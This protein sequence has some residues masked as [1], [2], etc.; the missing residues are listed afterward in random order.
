MPDAVDTGTDRV[1]LRGLLSRW[2]GRPATAGALLLRGSDP[3]RR[4]DFGGR[5]PVRSRLARAGEAPP[6]AGPPRYCPARHGPG[7]GARPA[8][9]LRRGL[10]NPAR[11]HDPGGDHVRDPSRRREGSATAA[12]LAGRSSVPCSTQVDNHGPV[13]LADRF[14]G[15]G[16][17]L[18]DPLAGDG[19]GQAGRRR[20]RRGSQGS[21][22]TP[23][24][25]PRAG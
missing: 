15:H 11:F 22:T 4:S 20:P 1:G 6:P 25:W 9:D 2:S 21:P 10:T 23:R 3:R 8:I 5:P 19:P 17:G 16:H 14:H 13:P 24:A 12:A 18:P 7:G